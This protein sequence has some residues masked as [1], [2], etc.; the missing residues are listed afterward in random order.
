MCKELPAFLA[1]PQCTVTGFLVQSSHIHS[2]ST[3]YLSWLK[4]C[5]SLL[6]ITILCLPKGTKPAQNKPELL[7]NW[8]LPI[9]FRGGRFR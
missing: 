9:P 1:G 3:Q 4:T 5:S 7:L 8:G 6:N 2:I